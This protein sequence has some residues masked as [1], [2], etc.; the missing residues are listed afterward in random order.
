MA[1]QVVNETS[2]SLNG[3]GRQASKL[4]KSVRDP[5]SEIEKTVSNLTHDIGEQAGVMVSKLTDSASDYYSTSRDYVKKNP[6]KGAAIAAAAG[7]LIGGLLTLS[8]RRK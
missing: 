1:N 3:A 8:M 7:I 4:A 6:A 2:T 5:F